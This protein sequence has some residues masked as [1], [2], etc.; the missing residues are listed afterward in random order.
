[1]VASPPGLQ[2]R[3]GRPNS[4]YRTMG[5]IERVFDVV[6]LLPLGRLRD[7][8]PQPCET[9]CCRRAI[10]QVLFEIRVL[11]DQACTIQCITLISK[12]LV[13]LIFFHR[14]NI[15][16]RIRD[17][18]DIAR[19]TANLQPGIRLPE[20]LV[21]H[22]EIIARDAVQIWFTPVRAGRSRWSVLRQVRGC[23]LAPRHPTP[24]QIWLRAEDGLPG[25]H[26]PLV[27]TASKSS[28]SLTSGRVPCIG[29][30]RGRLIL[31]YPRVVRFK[32]FIS[33]SAQ[34]PR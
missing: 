25:T 31:P 1:M 17:V 33:Q 27:C 5:V 14:P 34:A 10:G 12:S 22:E 6:Q 7:G 15:V 8:H 18:D 9:G 23:F 16:V 26:K 3:E 11:T 4:S 28:R 24:E 19:N 21:G 20:Q 2:S 29:L 30:Q 13:A 32:P